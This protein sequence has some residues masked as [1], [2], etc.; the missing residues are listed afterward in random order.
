MDKSVYECNKCSF[1]CKL[2]IHTWFTNIHLICPKGRD[3]CEWVETSDSPNKKLQMDAKH[4]VCSIC[5]GVNY[6]HRPMCSAGD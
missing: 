5:G 1:K 3:I 2:S 4:K 6:N